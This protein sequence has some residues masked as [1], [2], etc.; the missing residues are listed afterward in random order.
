MAAPSFRNV[1]NVLHNF[2][3]VITPARRL[4]QRFLDGSSYRNP[5]KHVDRN[6]PPN[7]RPDRYDDK[8]LN[9]STNDQLTTA[10]AISKAVV[11]NERNGTVNTS[12]G[13]QIHMENRETSWFFRSGE[14][15]HVI[16]SARSNAAAK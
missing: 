6:P 5:L 8:D 13:V 11:E 9:Q 16:G 4:V 10:S 2:K 15:S 14:I 1:N 7:E 3:L 12:N